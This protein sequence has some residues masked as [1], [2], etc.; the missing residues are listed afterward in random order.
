MLKKHSILNFTAASCKTVKVFFFL[1]FFTSILKQ[2]AYVSVN[3]SRNSEGNSCT[4][5][6]LSPIPRDNGGAQGL[7]VRHD[8]AVQ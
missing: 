7:S 8:Q 6:E 3:I 5:E 4:T 1:F 2:I